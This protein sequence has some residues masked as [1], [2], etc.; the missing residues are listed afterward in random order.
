MPEREYQV[1]IAADGAVELRINGHKGK[2]CLEVVKIFEQIVGTKKSQQL[3]AEFY[4][5]EEQVH[6]RIDQSR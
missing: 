4:E 5:P 2:G 3:T 6:Y 1:T